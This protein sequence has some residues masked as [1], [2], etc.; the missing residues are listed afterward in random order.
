[1]WGEKQEDIAIAFLVSTALF[2]KTKSL[3]MQSENLR[4]YISNVL[5]SQTT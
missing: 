4:K 3:I 2:P 1:M 5:L